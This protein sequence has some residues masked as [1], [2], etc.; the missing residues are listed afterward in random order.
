MS[1]LAKLKE[2]SA[3]PARQTEVQRIIDLPQ[4]EAD[5]SFDQ[6]SIQ[7]RPDCPLTLNKIQRQ[8]LSSLTQHNSLFGPIGVGWGKSWI[9]VLSG[10]ALKADLSI[11]LAPASTLD[12]LRLV[13][14]Q[15]SRHFWVPRTHVMSY[16]AL[17]QPTTTC[18]LSD[19]SKGHSKVVLVCDEAH[20]LK[21]MDSART[22][23][24]VRFMQSNPTTIFV[25]LSGT[26][27]SKSVK[28][29]A[30]L[31]EMALRDNTP[32]PRDPHDLEAWSQ[33]LD[34]D[35]R[36]TQHDFERFMPV[37]P[38][39]EG[40]SQQE[41]CRRTF[42][43]RL[44]RTPGVVAS[45][46]G[47]LGTSLVIEGITDVNIP[48]IINDALTTIESGEDLSGEVLVDDASV[49]RAKQHVTQGFFYQWDWPDGIPDYDYMDARSS[50]S[51]H[52]RAVLSTEARTGFDSPTLVA[53]EVERQL[54]SGAND[55][56]HRAYKRWLPYTD[57][58]PPPTKTI[59]LDDYLV[60]HAANWANTQSEPVIL[61]YSS[62]AVG[63]LL[64]SWGWPVYGAGDSPPLTPHTCAMSIKA[65][66]VGKN[67]Q[68]WSKAL[69]IAPP[70]GGLVWEQ[71]LGR[72]HR[73]G[74][75]ADEVVMFVYA[76]HQTFKDSLR[77]AVREARYIEASTGN[78]QKLLYATKTKVT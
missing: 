47:S 38:K 52:V 35:G 55:P 51:R 1:L 15:L 8:A 7:R 48:P 70:S 18:L 53:K 36:P 60:R 25:P 26:M 10:S 32:L 68:G 44:R 39:V 61:W 14:N 54:E 31:A 56:I 78:T 58:P 42:Q 21:R 71:L 28:D 65:H 3:G 2:R 66:G 63:E 13:L 46:V 5:D 73:Q 74:Q 49:W 20:K 50:W 41:R 34:S 19:I 6:T 33:V 67:L 29:F 45:D 37:D 64:R 43:H 40:T 12:N 76:H 69:V 22:K 27:T 59:W 9:A 17:S 72:S 75:Q 57:T 11:I 16:A 4:V 77:K 62:Q 23:R 24:V 30:H